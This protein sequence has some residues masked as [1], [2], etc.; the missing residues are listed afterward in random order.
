MLT[1]S[2]PSDQLIVFARPGWSLTAGTFSPLT[3]SPAGICRQALLWGEEVSKSCFNVINRNF[4]VKKAALITGSEQGL[5]EVLNFIVFTIKNYID[6][7]AITNIVVNRFF[8][9][10][11]QFAGWYIKETLK[12]MGH[13]P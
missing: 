12:A 9:L 10:C 13:L 1:I 2:P 11:Q 4:V 6:I 3:A 8:K 5:V 7:L